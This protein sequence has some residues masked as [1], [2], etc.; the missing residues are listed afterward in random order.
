MR[1]A[2]PHG[3]GSG[4]VPVWSPGNEVSISSGSGCVPVWTPGNEVSIS[5]GSGWVPV[6]TPGNKLSEI[7]INMPNFL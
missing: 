5:L 6:W 4:C 2:S 1:S 7:R 3:S